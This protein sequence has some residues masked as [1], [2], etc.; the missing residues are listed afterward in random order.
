MNENKSYYIISTTIRNNADSFPS[1]R[2]FTPPQLMIFA[3]K[4]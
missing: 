2:T 3:G 4:M 1:V